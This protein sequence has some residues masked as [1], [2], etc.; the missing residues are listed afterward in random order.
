MGLDDFDISD[1]VSC[2]FTLIGNE[3]SAMAW[4]IVQPP[5]GDESPRYYAAPDQSG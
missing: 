2:L 4:A 5:R 3:F 1:I